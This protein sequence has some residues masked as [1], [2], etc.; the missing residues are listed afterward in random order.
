MV[1][2]RLVLGLLP[3]AVALIHLL[4]RDKPEPQVGF[5]YTAPGAKPEV[6]F[7]D[8][9]PWPWLQESHT[10][11]TALGIALLVA[12]VFSWRSARTRPEAA[13]ATALVLAAVAW[14]VAWVHARLRGL[15]AH[16]R[17]AGGRRG[18][19]A[20]GG[21]SGRYRVSAP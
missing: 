17:S 19:H 12:V 13:L 16:R 1:L 14:P 10:L 15:A 9:Y 2:D 8:P 4:P 18:A 6:T 11:I 21:E 7:G 3:T 5:L 20:Q